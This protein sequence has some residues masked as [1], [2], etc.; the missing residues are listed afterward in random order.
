VRLENPYHVSPSLRPLFL[1]DDD[2]VD[3]TLFCRLLREANVP[4]PCKVFSQG[5]DMIDALIA[6]LRGAP[7]PLACFLDVRMPGMNG[8]DVLRWI[9]CQHALDDMAVVMLSSS[10]EPHHLNEAVHSGAQCYLA[11]FPNGEQLVEIVKEAERAAEASAGTA[12]KLTCNLLV[13]SP[14]ILG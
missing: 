4:H 3:R 5:E 14:Q 7:L 6:V 13:S 8:F 2:E 1:V 12:F 9:R 11:K 10:D